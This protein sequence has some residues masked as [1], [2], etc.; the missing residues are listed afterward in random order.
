[1]T[2]PGGGNN[3]VDPRFLSLFNCF[4]ITHPSKDSLFII[5]NTIL[6]SFLKEY[7]SNQFAFTSSITNVIISTSRCLGEGSENN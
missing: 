1:M 4:Y 7:N 2:P 6:R 3:S 5:Y